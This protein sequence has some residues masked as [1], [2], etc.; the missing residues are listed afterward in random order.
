MARLLEGEPDAEYEQAFVAAAI[1]SFES[2]MI[3]MAMDPG[4]GYYRP[5]TSERRENIL[6]FYER[7]ALGMYNG[8][9]KRAA[10]YA[11][12]GDARQQRLATLFREAQK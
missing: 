3:R 1:K 7:A 5:I 9:E 12:S 6:K 8:L 2:C 10:G 4:R 11:E